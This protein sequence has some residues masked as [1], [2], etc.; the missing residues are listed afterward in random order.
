MCL[1]SGDT[2][3]VTN[4][5][6]ACKALARVLSAVPHSEC[7]EN[8]FSFTA[9]FSESEQPADD[10]KYDSC[11]TQPNTLT[12]GTATGKIQHCHILGMCCDLKLIEIPLVLFFLSLVSVY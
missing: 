11:S 4:A 3:A 2:P 10:K 1:S 8:S 5:P 12:S 6:V 9:D 7:K